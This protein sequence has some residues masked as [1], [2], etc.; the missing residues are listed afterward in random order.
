MKLIRLWARLTGH[1]YPQEF[2]VLVSIRSW[3]N[4]RAIVRTEGLGQWKIPVTLSGI[5]NR[6]LPAFRAVPQST[7][8]PSA[9]SPKRNTTNLHIQTYEL[10][11]FVSAGFEIQSGHF[12][13]GGKEII[14]NFC[15][16]QGRRLSSVKLRPH[17]TILKSFWTSK[18]SFIFFT[19]I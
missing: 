19:E 13:A 5:W 4:S 3:I 2:L 9:P 7:A 18:N 12:S 1:L 10:S 11:D 6:D 17:Y 8:P 14:Y 16:I 15:A